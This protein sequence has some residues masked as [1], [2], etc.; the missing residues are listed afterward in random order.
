MMEYT[1]NHSH[2]YLKLNQ[3]QKINL[4]TLIQPPDPQYTGRAARG[5]QGC[6]QSLYYLY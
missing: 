5:L 1:I 2:P 4:N 6:L 3:N